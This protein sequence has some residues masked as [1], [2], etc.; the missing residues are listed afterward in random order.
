MEQALIE[1]GEDAFLALVASG[2][3]QVQD[4]DIAAFAQIVAAAQTPCAALDTQQL[5]IAHA[6]LALLR[7][8]LID[9]GLARAFE[10]QLS[11]V[12][13][14]GV[15]GTRRL[16]ALRGGEVTLALRVALDALGLLPLPIVIADRSL[17]FRPVALE[18]SHALIGDR[19]PAA[20]PASRHAGFGL[21]LQTKAGL[22]LLAAIAQLF[23]KRGITLTQM[24]HA[25]ERGAE[26]EDAPR[27]P[28]PGA[29]R[30]RPKDTGRAHVV[31]LY[32]ASLPARLHTARSTTGPAA[33][34]QAHE[35]GPLA[36]RLTERL[37]LADLDPRFLMPRFWPAK[38]N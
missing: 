31:L 8:A 27:T 4:Q 32:H 23:G 2:V 33:T 13:T 15:Q 36:H 9:V 25:T 34:L 16:P 35:G 11:L 19:T 24:K 3:D 26:P 22:D 38:R 14:L 29:R 20:K 10:L 28:P 1:R 7:Q 18:P 17:L 21:C 12:F 5:Q 6:T 30:G 37:A